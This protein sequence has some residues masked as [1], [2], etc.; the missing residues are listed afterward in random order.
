MDKPTLRPIADGWLIIFLCG[1][2]LYLAKPVLFPLI[3]ALFL[4]Y[5]FSP[6]L[7]LS[8]RLKIPRALALIILIGLDITIL[9]FFGV[10]FYSS[11]KSLTEQLPA[12]SQQFNFYLN[13]FLL[14]LHKWGVDVSRVTLLESLNINRLAGFIL[15]SLGTFLSFLGKLFLILVFL[16]FML[17]GR[18]KLKDK[19]QSSLETKRADNMVK[20]LDQIDRE[21]Q[22]YLVIKT[23]IS[24]LSA[25]FM[26]IILTFFGVNF[27]LTFALIAFFLN[28]I[29]SLGSIISIILPCLFSFLQ[30]GSLWRLFWVLILLVATDFVIANIL[31]PKIMGQ[32]LGLS[33]LVVLFSLFFWGWL[34]GVPG[35]IL[36]VP[37][38]AVLKITADHFPSLRFLSAL[39]SR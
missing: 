25:A 38:L 24:L 18:G 22:K 17:A 10:F 32:G 34:W 29:P 2:T 31:E 1:L 26:F 20:I 21:I 36:A 39:L 13:N 19:I 28:Y 27:A 14:K 11:G 37:V 5:I 3:M 15:S 16:F 35:M 4:Y 6:L 9:Y 12:Y 8:A 7:D 23:L 33:P 30:F